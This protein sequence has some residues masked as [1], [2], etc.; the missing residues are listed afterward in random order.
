MFFFTNSVATSVAQYLSWQGW[1][2]HLDV[3][4]NHENMYL[5]ELGARRKVG[6]EWRTHPEGLLFLLAARR[7]SGL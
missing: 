4:F 3:A 5:V 6:K 1:E 2:V 7:R